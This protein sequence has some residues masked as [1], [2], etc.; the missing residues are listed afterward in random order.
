MSYAGTILLPCGSLLPDS[1]RD[2]RRG[3][4]QVGKLDLFKPYL[5]ERMRTVVWNARVLLREF[6][7]SKMMVPQPM[8]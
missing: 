1:T 8:A 2:T 6:R 7:A 3:A 4:V 5:E